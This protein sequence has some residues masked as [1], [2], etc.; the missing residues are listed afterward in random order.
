M[1][2]IRDVG[3]AV[4]IEH[5]VVGNRREEIKWIKVRQRRAVGRLNVGL[6]LLGKANQTELGAERVDAA[7]AIDGDVAQRAGPETNT[8]LP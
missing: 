1:Q 6:S 2:G 5:D 3:V 8:E 7:L 4:V